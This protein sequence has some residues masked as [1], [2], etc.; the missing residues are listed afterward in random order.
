MGHWDEHLAIQTFINDLTSDLNLPW[1]NEDVTAFLMGIAQ[2]EIYDLVVNE[3]P[4]QVNRI[5]FKN[6]DL[7][8]EEMPSIYL[9]LVGIGIAFWKTFKRY[10]EEK[11]KDKLRHRLLGLLGAVTPD[12]LEGLRLILLPN[13]LKAWEQGNAS[14]FHINQKNWKYPIDTFNDPEKDLKRRELMQNLTLSIEL[15]KIRF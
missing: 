13:G 9:N 2:H 10:N 14:S 7:F 8:K 1:L 4:I 15:F 12:I 6:I 5:D 11:D 3:R